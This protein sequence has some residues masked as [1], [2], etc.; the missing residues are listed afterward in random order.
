MS[1]T[2]ID[3]KFSAVV[4]RDENLPAWIEALCALSGKSSD[5]V[6]KTMIESA[7]YDA[8][9]KFIKKFPELFRTGTGLA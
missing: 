5:E 8:G 4:E 2:Q 3:M 7:M 1:A 6:V 9:E